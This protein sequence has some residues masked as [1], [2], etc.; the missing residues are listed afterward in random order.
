MVPKHWLYHYSWFRSHELKVPHPNLSL[1]LKPK[2]SVIGLKRKKDKTQPLQKSVQTA[3]TKWVPYHLNSDSTVALLSPSFLSWS[4]PVAAVYLRATLN[5]WRVMEWAPPQRGK[6]LSGSNK[7]II[8][9]I[10]CECWDR[11]SCMVVWG[12]TVCPDTPRA[13]WLTAWGCSWWGR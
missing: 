6:T 9:S 7:C 11:E 3:C 1:E 5:E 8:L 13:E 2:Q 4:L 12:K 10:S